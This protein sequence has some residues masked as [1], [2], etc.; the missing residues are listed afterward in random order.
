MDEALNLTPNQMKKFNELRQA[1]QQATR[2]YR[3]KLHEVVRDSS[4]ANP[5]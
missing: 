2:E 1:I 3:E 5:S 4:E